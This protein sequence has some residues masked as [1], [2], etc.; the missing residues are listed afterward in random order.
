V[1]EHTSTDPVTPP[2]ALQDLGWALGTL[3]RAYLKQL[4][5]VIAELPGG[6][7]AYQ[8]MTMAASGRCQNQASIAERLGLDRTSLTYLL[9]GL[10]A[11][12]LVV[13][14]PDP[15]D[16]RARQVGLT[17]KGTDVLAKLTER[18]RHIEQSVLSG[19]PD[20]EAAQLRVLLGK[21][22]RLAET[23]DEGKTLCQ[24]FGSLGLTE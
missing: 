24:E 14:T 8:A 20:T 5:G 13:R 9:D 7:R 4:Q 1:A 23:G 19:L 21:A 10:E 17:D 18:V 3:L 6:P 12:K 22:A 16:R 11:Q 2:D 15:V